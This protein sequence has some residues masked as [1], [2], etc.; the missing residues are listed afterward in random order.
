MVRGYQH[1]VWTAAIDQASYIIWNFS[2]VNI[3]EDWLFLDL[4]F[5]GSVLTQ[6]PPTSTTHFAFFL[7]CYG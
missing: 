2:R 5:R 3:F 4:Y 1:D 7:G 6:A